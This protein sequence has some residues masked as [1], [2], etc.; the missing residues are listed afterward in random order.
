[1]AD[2]LYKIATDAD[3]QRA[4]ATG[5]Y[6][7]S[8]DDL[9]DGFI[10]FSLRHQVEGTARKYFR[11]QRGLWL[12]A[13]DAGLVGDGLRMEAS[14]GGEAFPHLYGPLPLNAVL[15]SEALVM[16]GETL[17]WPARAHDRP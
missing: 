10:H 4:Q 16:D 6:A 15:W 11:G 8:A 9:R 12:L 3:W 14:R 7:G 2:T 17:V 13:V 5:S 1:M